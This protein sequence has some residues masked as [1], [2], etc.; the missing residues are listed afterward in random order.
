MK[1]WGAGWN[2]QQFG[3]VA[4]WAEG[5]GQACR[6]VGEGR[7]PGILPGLNVGEEVYLNKAHRDDVNLNRIEV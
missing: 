5:M 4:L 3:G 2:I 7:G 6:R 1:E